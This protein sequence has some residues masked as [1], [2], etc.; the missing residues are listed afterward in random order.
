MA[1]VLL[2]IIYIAFISLGLPDSVLGTAWPMMHLDLGV[3][4][5]MAG[6]VN[7]FISLCTI[8]A[9]M[10]SQHVIRRFGTYK[11][12]IFSIAL[13]CSGLYLISTSRHILLL[14]LFCIP[15]GLGG[16]AIDTALNN[17][18]ANHY[19]AMQMN[20][21]HAF[22]GIGT[23]VAPSLL[24]VFFDTGRTWR[25]GYIVLALIQS[26]IFL[27]VLSSRGLWKVHEEKGQDRKR[28]LDEDRKV[29]SNAQLLRVPGALPSCLA[30]TFYCFESVTILW[31]ASYLVYGK[32]LDAATA[33]GLSSM[34]YL[35]ITSGRIATAF[36]ADRIPSKR[37]IQASQVMIALASLAL[38]PVHSIPVLYLVI[39]V[40]GFSF[41][42]IF[43]TMV[44]QT[45]SY[46]HPSCS[47]G[48]IGLQMS[49]A[50]I[51]NTLLVPLYGV[52]AAM[53]GTQALFPFYVLVLLVLQTL[54]TTLKNR[55]CGK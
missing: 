44:H 54:S 43:P 26:V 19:S 22:W 8:V 32:R 37:M 50:Y 51:G 49:F 40:M 11:V 38:I 9:S 15:L 6:I 39:F 10:M 31:L 4:V 33:A 2:I 35:G 5:S 41:G 23:M 28:L 12:T 48:I 24:S 14:M 16:G 53:L 7:V 42:P 17:Y 21:L 52:I 45:V 34:T 1:T 55:G 47:V 36:I 27:V 3:P 18:V 25:D 13:T 29:Y 30:F 46:F 20:F